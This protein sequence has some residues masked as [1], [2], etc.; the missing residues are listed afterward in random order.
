MARREAGKY[1]TTE[2]T[3][4]PE[5]KKEAKQLGKQLGHKHFSETAIVA[6]EFWLNNQHKI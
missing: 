3:I 5:L 6:F 1:P 4:P 2:I